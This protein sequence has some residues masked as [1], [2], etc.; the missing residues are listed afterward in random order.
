MMM[1]AI[2]SSNRGVALIITLLM[3]SIIVVLTLEF[4][5]SMRHEF[6]GAV[7]SRDNIMLGYIAK[8]GYNLALAILREDDSGSDSLNDDWALLNEA[9]ALSASLFEEGMFHVEIKDL[10]GRIQINELIKQ[11]GSYNND[12]K[13]ILMRLLSSGLFELDEEEAEDILDN[14]KDW[15]DSDDEP[16]RYGSENSYYQSLENPYSCRNGKLRSIYEMT[17]IKGV[18]KELFFGTNETPALKDFLTVYGDGTGRININTADRN[19]LMVLSDDLDEEMADEILKYRE[20]EDNDLSTVLWY[21]DALGTSEDVIKP[22]L[23]TVKSS[24]FEIL[25]RGL[26]DSA[27]KELRAIVKRAESKFSTLSYEII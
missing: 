22:S 27:V 8:S 13:D 16:T 14:I 17:Q 11:D 20:D 23:L 18:T 6:Y 3:I 2:L 15:I 19:I 10:S 1:K 4:N 7:N 12:Q 21:K 25:S 26:R 9:S 24:Y 5:S